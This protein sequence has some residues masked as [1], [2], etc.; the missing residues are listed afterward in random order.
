MASTCPNGHVLR[1]GRVLIGW[2][3]C[4]RCP[5]TAT[6]QRGL[7]GH[8]TVQCLD[9]RDNGVETVRYEPPCIHGGGHPNRA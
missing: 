8:R 9:C 6:A 3:P 4:T 2:S 5:A 1:P 7:R